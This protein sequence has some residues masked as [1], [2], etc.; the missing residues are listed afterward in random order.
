MASLFEQPI[1][2]LKGVGKKRAELFKKL[3]V[4]SV[5]DLICYYPRTYED[6]SNFVNISDLKAEEI[7]CIKAVVT[8]PPSESRVSGGRIITKVRLADDSGVVTATFFNNRYIKNMLAYNSEYVFMGRVHSSMNRLELISP[9]FVPTNKAKEIRPIY[10][11]TAGLT[12]RQIETTVINALQLLPEKIKESIPDEIRDKYDLITYDEAIRCVHFPKNKDM[13][14]KARK[15]LIFQELLVLSLGLYSMKSGRKRE[16]AVEINKSYADEYTKLLPFNM[17]SGQK[18]A[19]LDC[20]NDMLSCKSPM[21]RLVQGDVGCG[22]TAVAAGV[23]FTVVKNGYQVAF[24]APTEILAEQHYHSLVSLFAGT[25][26]N[27]EL[28]V[29][30]VTA[31]QKR[32]IKDSIVTGACDLVVGTHAL[33]S[34]T[35]EFRN[36]GLV[37]TDEQHRFGVVQRNT[38]VEKGENP[39]LLIMSATPIPRTLALIVYGDLDIS[40]ID[41]M[42]PGRQTIDTFLVNSKKR[43]GMY[44]FIKEH[45]DRG[46]QCYIVCPA[47]EENEMFNIAA[48]EQYAEKIQDNEFKDYSI[49]VLHG[50]MKPALKEDIMSR[51]KSGE[52]QLLVSTTVVEVGVDVP[53]A[54][55]IVIENAERFGLSQLHQLRGRVG[56]GSE[57]SYCILMSDNTNPDTQQR[58]KTMCATNNGFEIADTDLKLR[59]P[60]DFFGSRQHGL[61][62]MKIADLANVEYLKTASSASEEILK[63]DPT[64]QLQEHRLLKAEVKRLF[65]KIGEGGFN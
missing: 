37:I 50:K 12:T 55:V 1:E 53:N 49:G 5:G 9:D 28:L 14:M 26:V 18:N 22:K 57:K 46:R 6:W 61:P 20:I 23:S 24:M 21:S 3:G 65:A 38:L 7:C 10:G 29:G 43:V 36:L 41:T 34:D 63:K 60:G 25:G 8:A 33:L 2:F 19:M 42:P 64:L 56:R 51:F 52:I 30:G 39:H 48:A 11:C 44:G 54:T 59:G 13:L 62:E 40:I 4:N 27:V 17:T 47:V 58:L 15:R 16:T 31:S 32:R 45:L 35:V